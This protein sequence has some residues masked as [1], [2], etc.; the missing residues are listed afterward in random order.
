MVVIVVLLSTVLASLALGFESELEEPI[1]AEAFEYEYVPAGEDNGDKPYVEITHEA[2]R[3]L[4][5]DRILIKDDSGNTVAWSDVWTGGSHVNASEFVHIDGH[6]SDGALDHV[7]EAGQTYRV[8]LTRAD[9]TTAA[10]Y[11]WTVPRAPENP[12]AGWC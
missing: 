2:G 3:T 11:D 6:S 12:P 8:V 4:D 7:C 1:P 5:A 9:G 10:I